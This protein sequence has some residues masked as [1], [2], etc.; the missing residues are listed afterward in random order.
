VHLAAAPAPAVSGKPSGG[1]GTPGVLA[2]TAT[3]E[4]TSTDWTA[5][6]E[7][8]DEPRRA[9]RP[10]KSEVGV[11]GEASKTTDATVEMD[12]AESEMLDFA[13]EAAASLGKVSEA[14]GP[15]GPALAAVA[16]GATVAIEAFRAVSNMFDGMVERYKQYSPQMATAEAL[17]E[18]RNVVGDL[19]RAQEGGPDLAKYMIERGEVEQ[20][21]EDVK[22]EFM[23]AVM[24]IMLTMLRF[25]ESVIL[26]A[27]KKILEGIN[28]LTAGLTNVEGTI[29]DIDD[30]LGEFKGAQEAIREVSLDAAFMEGF[31]DPTSR[32]GRSRDFAGDPFVRV[33]TDKELRE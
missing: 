8:G 17:V 22:I 23:K 19:R 27:V 1:L 32:P 26:P 5:M 3:V 25:F 21:I 20:K 11:F 28:K 6:A 29:N 18:V 13:E 15:V 4:H 16:V 33:P 2:A 10:G 30:L 31:V 9:P 7:F 14:A 24:P 12:R